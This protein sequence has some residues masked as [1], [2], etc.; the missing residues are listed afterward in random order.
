[1]KVSHDSM[2]SMQINPSYLVKVMIIHQQTMN[3]ISI[4]TRFQNLKNLITSQLD[5][6]VHFPMMHDRNDDLRCMHIL[7]TK[8]MLIR[9][10]LTS[11]ILKYL[12]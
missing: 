7:V 8:V 9:K 10:G 11:S 4:S 1:M 12:N 3:T 2:H 5:E 6:V